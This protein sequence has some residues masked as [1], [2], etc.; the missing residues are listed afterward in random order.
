MGSEI[1]RPESQEEVPTPMAEVEFA[2]VLSRMIDSVQNDPEHLR[3][4]IY[5]LARVK[6]KEQSASQSLEDKRQLS[7]ALETAIHCVETFVKKNEIALPRPERAGQSRAL[8]TPARAETIQ[9]EPP[10]IE[11]GGSHWSVKRRT[12]ALTAPWR[13]GIVLA[14]ALTVAL[15]ITQRERLR[16]NAGSVMAMV[17]STAPKPVQVAPRASVA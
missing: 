1:L 16:N 4:T 2:L 12:F 13:F 6:M 14:I 8:A 10:Y 7:K 5:E 3:A 9:S 17:T 11:V 15:G